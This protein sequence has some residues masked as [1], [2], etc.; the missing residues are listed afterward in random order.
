MEGS[1][2]KLELQGENSKKVISDKTGYASQCEDQSDPMSLSSEFYPLFL[3]HLRCVTR[4]LLEFLVFPATYD[5]FF[6]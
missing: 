4:P 1:Y 3:T 6:L 5:A 2:R